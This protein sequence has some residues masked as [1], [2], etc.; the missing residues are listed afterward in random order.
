VAVCLAYHGHGE[1]VRLPV[2]VRFGADLSERIFGLTRPAVTEQMR[3]CYNDLTEATEY[4][5][6]GIAILVAR[7]LTALTIVK[8]SRK[9]TG[10]DY[11]LGQGKSDRQLFEETARLEVSGILLGDRNVVQGRIQQKLDQTLRSAA[12]GLPAYVVVVEFGYPAAYVIRWE[13]TK[14]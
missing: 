5:A 11:W 9:G 13:F 2:Q 6:C 10:F 14:P 8:R 3:L 7:E 12:S 4:G 1:N